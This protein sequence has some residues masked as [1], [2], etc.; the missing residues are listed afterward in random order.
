MTRALVLYLGVL[1]GAFGI[2]AGPQL[3]AKPP[4]AVIPGI[5]LFS[6][7]SAILPAAF[8]FAGFAF[9]RLFL[10]HDARHAML[11]GV[12]LVLAF[13]AAGTRHLAY[14]WTASSQT[15]GL[16]FSATLFLG[17]LAVSAVCAW[18]PRTQ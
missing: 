13:V 5:V 11:F 12:G 16:A 4:L 15:A 18:K 1:V 3:L 9:G 10:R 2:E 14:A 17:G 6:V 7:F 8:G